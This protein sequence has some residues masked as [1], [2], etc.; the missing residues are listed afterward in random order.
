[1]G[2]GYF[3]HKKKRYWMGVGNVRTCRD[4]E[5]LIEAGRRDEKELA[6]FLA[7]NAVSVTTPAETF[8]KHPM[9]Q[10]FVAE[11]RPGFVDVPESE[12]DVESAVK[13][14]FTSAGDPGAAV[15]LANP[16]P[17]TGGKGER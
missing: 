9:Q 15:E 7:R 2:F 13:S 5:E 8:F 10:S 1:M 12:S 3:D 16:T 4:L 6:E 14:S 17:K 11:Q